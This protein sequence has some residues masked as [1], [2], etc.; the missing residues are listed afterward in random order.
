MK[1]IFNSLGSNYDLKF[2]FQSFF[3]NGKDSQELKNLLETKYDGKVAFTYKGR[4]SI[5][6]VLQSLNL[7]AKS[8][9]AINGFTCLAVEQAIKNA[10]FVPL[11][12]DIDEN[13]L[14]F[15]T[16]TL[17]KAIV[18][19][20]GIKAVII[21]NTL[22]WPCEAEEIADICSDQNIDLIEDLAHS[23][24][25]T[26][27]SGREAGT[28]SKF[29]IFSFGQDKIIDA[30]SGGAAVIK[31]GK[32]SDTVFKSVS[33]SKQI[34]DRLYPAVTWKI[35]IL[36][37]FFG[38]GKA[39]HVFSKALNLLPKPVLTGMSGIFELPNWYQSLA[40]SRFLSLDCNIKH[41]QSIAKVYLTN[42]NDKFFLPETMLVE[43]S[44]CLRFPIVVDQRDTI[45]KKL[46]AEGIHLADIW[47]DAPI[48]PKKYLTLTDY[49]TGVCPNAE[50]LSKKMLNLPTHQNM[51][52]KTAIRISKIINNYE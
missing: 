44:T 20:P 23:V 31:E 33:I 49:K 42:L 40:F 8:K 15:S 37:P 1:N 38:L 32:I 26:Y 29:A 25:T 41:R 6:F 17:K 4:Q 10:G 18:D 5:E 12:L 30:I 16:S 45:V 34:K 47:Y 27:R 3:A 50:K 52:E 24:G 2:V 11:Y 9:I 13:K 46:K 39:L 48:A 43:S 22:G 28:I 21:Q 36:Y 14:N 35:R 7:P 51:T 19:N